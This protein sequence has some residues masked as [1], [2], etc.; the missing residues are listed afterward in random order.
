MILVGHKTVLITSQDTECNRI[1]DM[2]FGKAWVR[3]AKATGKN[4]V[5][6]VLGQTEAGRH[7]FVL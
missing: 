7:L 5:Y 6:Y 1:E 4:P 2:C 3:R